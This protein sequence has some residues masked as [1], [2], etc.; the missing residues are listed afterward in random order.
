MIKLLFYNTDLT[1]W[2]DYVMAADYL[3]IERHRAMDELQI[4]IA[5]NGLEARLMNVLFCHVVEGKKIS[6]WALDRST[7]SANKEDIPAVGFTLR[8]P[9]WLLNTR[10]AKRQSFKKANLAGFTTTLINGNTSGSRA[11]GAIDLSALSSL[12]TSSRITRAVDGEP[13]ADLLMEEYEAR[14]LKPYMT[15]DITSG[16][17]LTAGV[18]KEYMAE[19]TVLSPLLGNMRVNLAKASNE[20]NVVYVSGEWRPEGG[21]EPVTLRGSFTYGEA[22]LYREEHYTKAEKTSDDMTRA[23]YQEYLDM[24]AEKI[25]KRRAINY[26]ISVAGGVLAGMEIEGRANRAGIVFPVEIGGVMAKYMIE[27][28]KT[29]PAETTVGVCKYKEAVI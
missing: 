25:A 10:V 20:F 12:P 7:V 5:D 28:I 21:G 15:L 23:E 9:L 27:E 14:R 26:D 8:E 19:E 18:Q 1:P 22:G 13:L 24:Q 29:T 11:L 16:L 4:V 2:N 3:K 17:A 6:M